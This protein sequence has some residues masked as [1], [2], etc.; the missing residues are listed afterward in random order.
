MKK[1]Y[2]WNKYGLRLQFIKS[3]KGK[4]WNWLFLP[5][6]PGLGSESLDE[7]TAYLDLPG[8]MWHIDLPGDG[9]N[10]SENNVESFKKWPIALEEVVDAFDN[11]ILVGHSSGGMYALSLPQLEQKLS[12][13]IL[14][15]SAPDA[16]W[17]RE[18]ANMIQ[19]SPIAEL[20]RLDKIYNTNPNNEILKELT[21][22][23]APYFFTKKGLQKGKNLLQGLPYNCET[24]DWSEEHFDSTYKAQ[25]FPQNLLTLVIA[26]TEDHL[27]PIRLFKDHAKFNQSNILIKDISDAGHFPWIENPSGVATA[28]DEF[29]DRL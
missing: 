13:L 11:V 9:S 14:M 19:A 18:L 15:D 24:C 20:D 4:A 1:K 16:S 3:H 26:G 22:A 28:F 27:T 17:Q 8:T 7:L 12:G 2:L 29:L 21:V 25:W 23:A 5:G 6:G 10:T